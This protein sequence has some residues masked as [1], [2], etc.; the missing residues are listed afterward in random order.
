MSRRTLTIG[1]L[2]LLAYSAGG[3]KFK[4]FHIILFCAGL[5]LLW[6]IGEARS[7]GIFNYIEGMRQENIFSNYYSMPGGGANIF[8]SVI[9]VVDLIR[10]GRLE[11]PHTM[12]VLLWPSGECTKHHICQLRLHVNGGMH[13]ASILYWNFGLLGVVLGGMAI[14]RI[15]RAAGNVSP[16]L[17]RGVG[18]HPGENGQYR[19]LADHA[20]CSGTIQLG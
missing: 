14:G 20:I 1:L 16:H 8:V 12:P 15:F 10:S 17:S 18:R 6:F 7:V 5:F 2:M 11:F 19:N 4:P 13:I 9:G 3:A